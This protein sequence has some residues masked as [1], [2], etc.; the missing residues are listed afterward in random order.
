M[1][2][3]AHTYYSFR[4]GTLSVRELLSEAQAAGVRVLAL[5]DI[6]STSASLDFVRLAPQYGIRP[7]LGVDFRNGVQPLFVA[8]A[9][10]NDG[11]REINAYLSHFYAI[12]KPFPHGSQLQ[13]GICDL[14]LPPLP[15]ACFAGA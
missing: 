14:P 13:I 10:N 12:K 6:N 4:Y 7:V 1:Y 5:T 8:L 3:N 11:Y 9:Q 15:R 2:L